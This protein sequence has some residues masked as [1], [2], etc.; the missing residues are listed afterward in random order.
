MK[1]STTVMSNLWML[2]QSYKKSIGN[3]Y[4]LCLSDGIEVGKLLYV[5]GFVFHQQMVVYRFF[6]KLMGVARSQFTHE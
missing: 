2:N 1:I 5:R 4:Q 3:V 6:F